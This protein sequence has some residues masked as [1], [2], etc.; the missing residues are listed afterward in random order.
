MPDLEFRLHGLDGVLK[1]M[2][3]L[4]D[5]I[6]RKVARR[7]VRKGANLVAADAR[8]GAQAIDDPKT[9]ESIAR[10]IVVQESAKLGRAEGGVA[11]RV[12]V[13]G[14]ARA[15]ARAAGEIKGG[16]KGNPGGDT[17]YWRFHEFGTSKMQA[18]PFLRPALA[19]NI[20]KATDAITTELIRGLDKHAPTD[21]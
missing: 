1:R 7:A 11:M 14:G 6:Q 12:G 8:T 4:P 3:S 5:R 13:L 21:L 17:Y 16:G 2:R 9:A 10:N 15:P 18:R 20:E 19:G